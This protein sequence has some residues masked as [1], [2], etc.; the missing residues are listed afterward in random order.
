MP[1]GMV[2]PRLIPFFHK[3]NTAHLPENIFALREYHHAFWDRCVAFLTLERTL[4]EL[5]SVAEAWSGCECDLDDPFIRKL[6]D[7]TPNEIAMATFAGHL[8]STS[9]VR[10]PVNEKGGLRAMGYWIERSPTPL[11]VG[12]L[13]SMMEI[14]KQSMIPTLISS[15][16][17]PEKSVGMV[18]VPVMVWLMLAYARNGH[19]TPASCLADI[20]RCAVFFLQLQNL[21]D[22]DELELLQFFSGHEEFLF[23]AMKT[24][25]DKLREI[26]RG[27][28][29]YTA[30][31]E[32]DD[33][34]W[35]SKP[36]FS[37][38]FTNDAAR[39][40]VQKRSPASAESFRSAAAVPGSRAAQND[41]TA[42]K[43]PNIAHKDVCKKM[44]AIAIATKLPTK[45][46]PSDCFEDIADIALHKEMSSA[47]DGEDKTQ[48]LETVSR[49]KAIK[50]ESAT[51][52]SEAV[53]G[54]D[55]MIPSGL[56][57]EVVK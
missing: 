15:P 6:H 28:K 4:E 5:T 55:T 54:G 37:S 49:F 27:V 25:F 50:L 30:E 40:G 39:R 46:S 53:D 45:P 48:F 17:I 34:L 12:L 47:F 22:R 16:Y 20:K 35:H 41:V 23:R 18:E 9:S 1:I 33:T 7:S 43:Y 42:W 14:C 10:Q 32:H 31:T 44:K 57:A 26:A 36:S 56:P 3:S 38:L 11:W 8:V 2:D 13:G 29:P 19:A 21:C 52:K 24:S 51:T